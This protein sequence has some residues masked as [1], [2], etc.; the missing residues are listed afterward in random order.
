[1]FWK[2]IRYLNQPTNMK[3]SFLF[4]CSQSVFSWTGFVPLLS[5]LFSSFLTALSLLQLN[6]NQNCILSVHNESFSTYV[7]NLAVRYG[8]AIP[9]PFCYLFE[10]FELSF[11]RTHFCKNLF[12]FCPIAH[13]LI[14]L[15]P[16]IGGQL[17]QKW[18]ERKKMIKTTRW[19]C[20]E[21]LLLQHIP[22]PFQ[23]MEETHK[24]QR[25]REDTT[26]PH[27]LL[28]DL[29]HCRQNFHF[30]PKK[31]SHVRQITMK[32]TRKYR[33]RVPKTGRKER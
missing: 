31:M 24:S 29:S 26:Q 19:E 18:K 4:Y 10:Q 30:N 23:T 25:R 13:V 9:D 8:S 5:L 21:I 14:C 16:K 11:S 32:R 20:S 2:R 33:V 27:R 7:F 1:M 22:P 3:K 28:H 6:E 15:D 17:A 12:L